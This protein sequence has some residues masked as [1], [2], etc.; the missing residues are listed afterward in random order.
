[1]VR[2]TYGITHTILHIMLAAQFSSNLCSTS[3]GDVDRGEGGGCNVS[4][5]H[6]PEDVQ[7]NLI[8]VA[9]WLNLNDR[10]EFMNVYASVREKPF[11]LETFPH[12][13]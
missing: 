12:N 10:D 1:M 3:L 9:E 13:M 7:T 4:I 2:P 5:H 6:F 11:K 8:A